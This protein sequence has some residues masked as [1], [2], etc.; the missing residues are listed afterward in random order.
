MV[1]RQNH[2][3]VTF[4]S[5]SLCSMRVILWAWTVESILFFKKLRQNPILRWVDHDDF[6]WI[7]TLASAKL[8]WFPVKTQKHNPDSYT[9]EAN[10]ARWTSK[11][12]HLRII[13][14][15]LWFKSPDCYDDYH[16]SDKY[17]SIMCGH[18]KKRQ[19][20]M[21]NFKIAPNYHIQNANVTLSKS[22]RW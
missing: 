9:G 14:V 5:S 3:P 21:M 12:R 2:L 11:V 15:A 17:E 6:L 16:N 7:M 8:R 19:E 1:F 20:N 10:F 13:A 4:W 22:K 18:W